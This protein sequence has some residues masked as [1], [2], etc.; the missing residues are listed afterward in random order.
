MNRITLEQLVA[1]AKAGYPERYKEKND[2]EGLELFYKSNVYRLVDKNVEYQFMIPKYDHMSIAFEGDDFV[3][4]H[5]GN[6]KFNHLA[7]IDKMKEL[8]I[9]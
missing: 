5:V 2:L 7:A 3:Q 6:K 1:V 9:I 8:K 4:I